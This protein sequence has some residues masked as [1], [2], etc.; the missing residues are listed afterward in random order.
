MH[1]RKRLDPDKLKI[2]RLVNNAASTQQ[3]SVITSRS[4]LFTPSPSAAAAAAYLCPLPCE[5]LPVVFA[6]PLSCAVLIRSYS[7]N[8]LDS[9]LHRFIGLTLISIWPFDS[10]SVIPVAQRLSTILITCPDSLNSL[11]SINFSYDVFHASFFACACVHNFIVP[12]T[13]VREEVR[14]ESRYSSPL[15]SSVSVSSFILWLAGQRNCFLTSCS[16]CLP[17]SAS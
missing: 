7:P 16:V 17:V 8:C 10:Q 15:H 14:W 3:R 12:E 5:D 9:S 2:V 13:G 4:L 11:L 6:L 1:S